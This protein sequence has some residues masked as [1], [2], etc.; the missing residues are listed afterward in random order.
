MRGKLPSAKSCRADGIIAYSHDLSKR[1]LL[2]HLVKSLAGL[3]KKH[4]RQALITTHN[5]A[6]LDG[7]NLHDDEQRLFVI[8]RNHARHTQ[9]KRVRVKPETE[10]PKLKLS[11]LWM[12][13]S[14][15]S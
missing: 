7:L 5:P 8:S 1:H 10:G 6:A 4:G 2:R 3:A 15:G 13:G 14:A 12:R 11:E 9:A